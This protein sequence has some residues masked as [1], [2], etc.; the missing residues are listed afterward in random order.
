MSW[1]FTSSSLLEY[2]GIVVRHA[3]P[4]PPSSP[5]S[6]ACQHVE[7]ARLLAPSA[8]F[9]PWVDLVRRVAFGVQHEGVVSLTHEWR[10]LDAGGLA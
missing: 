5:Q 4:P 7:L 2:P 3:P 8:P 9:T 6:D 1:M 10:V